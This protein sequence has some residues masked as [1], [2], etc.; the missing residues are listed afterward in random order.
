MQIVGLTVDIRFGIHS[1]YAR[2]TC[3]AQNM[4]SQEI[5]LSVD[6]CDSVRLIRVAIVGDFNF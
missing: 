1:I 5:R 6:P 2:R 3:I 4:L